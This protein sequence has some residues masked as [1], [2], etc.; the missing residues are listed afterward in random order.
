MDIKTGI[1][2]SP[3]LSNAQKATA[4]LLH[5]VHLDWFGVAIAKL[6]KGATMIINVDGRRSEEPWAGPHFVACS[7]G[8]HAVA[9][10]W[11][12]HSIGGRS[13]AALKIDVTVEAGRVTELVYKVQT[14]T[15]HGPAAASIEITGTRAG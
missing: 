9:L 3:G 5:A 4:E 6:A 11:N 14:L 12:S 1:E 2:I 10:E 15:T 8:T 7:P 13:L